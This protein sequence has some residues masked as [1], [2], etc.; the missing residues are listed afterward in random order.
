ME[1]N[2][3]GQASLGFPTQSVGIRLLSSS[4]CHNSMAAFAT[5][6]PLCYNAVSRKTQKDVGFRKL[7]YVEVPKQVVNS[8]KGT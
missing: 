1:T 4:P 3:K 8:E 5:V 2:W 6:Q 7:D